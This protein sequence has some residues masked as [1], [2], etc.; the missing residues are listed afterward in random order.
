M[1]SRAGRCAFWEAPTWEIRERSQPGRVGG[2]LEETDW[3][4]PHPSCP[5]LPAD[6]PYT[7]GPGWAETSKSGVPL[8]RALAA[9]A[10]LATRGAIS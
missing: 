9:L 8:G 3:E 10:V 5:P 2:H 1:A 7:L 4:C 6:T